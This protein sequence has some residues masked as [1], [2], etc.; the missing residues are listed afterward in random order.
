M[1][2]YGQGGV[3]ADFVGMARRAR[4]K[5]LPDV[6]QI[7]VSGCSGNVT[8]G[9]YNDG[10]PD[11]RPLLASRIETAMAQSWAATKRFSLEEAAFR[12]VPLRFEPRSDAGFTKE[13]LTARLTSDVRPFGQCLAALGLSW[14][15]R[16]ESGQTVDLPVLDLGPAVVLLLP[17]RDLR[18]VSAPGP[19]AP[20]RR[21]RHGHRLWRISAG[22]H[23]HRP[24]GRRARQQSSRLVLGC[25]EAQNGPSGR[26]SSRA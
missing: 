25:T 19:E 15:E 6:T 2:Y 18:R 4:Q 3:S 13:D 24:S 20:P 22:L 14:R 7:Y 26:P 21:V 11:N 16:V 23:S 5:A 1:S 9:K 12:L 8:A 17:G 10:S